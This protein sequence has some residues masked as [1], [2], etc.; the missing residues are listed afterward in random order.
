MIQIR[1]ILTLGR[2]RLLPWF[3]AVSQSLAKQNAHALSALGLLAVA[4]ALHRVLRGVISIARPTLS[5]VNELIRSAFTRAKEQLSQAARK[6]VGAIRSL[7]LGVTTGVILWSL[8]LRELVRHFAQALRGGSAAP[9][10]AVEEQ[11][12]WRELEE[13]GFPAFR[14]AA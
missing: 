6:I 3:T 4:P 14:A 5:K 9:A 1:H 8:V 10:R 13:S 11:E 7:A 2:A 12:F